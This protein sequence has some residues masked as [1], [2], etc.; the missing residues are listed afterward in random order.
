MLKPLTRSAPIRRA[1][2]KPA[3]PKPAAGTKLKACRVCRTKFLPPSPMA[4]VCCVDCAIEHSRAV[5]A[6]QKAKAKAAERAQD[7]V[8]REALKTRADWQREAQV[9]LNAYV[10]ARDK[11]LPCI[12]CG[13]HHEG[14]YHAGHF[15]SR[16]SHP[17]LALDERNIAKQCMP[18]NVY[19][20]GNQLNFR[21]GLI[22]RLGMPEVE[23]L[24][25][26]NTPRK[27]TIDDLKAIKAMYRAK[28]KALKE[29]A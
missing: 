6:K 1:G 12:S 27:Y 20:S 10:R 29:A 26:D 8:K 14:Q 15:L 22:A 17:H 25:S 9:A 7:R 21:R 19:L 18:C 11:A 5:A 23:A 13:R 2:Y 3:E 16:G 28:L 4:V 24:E